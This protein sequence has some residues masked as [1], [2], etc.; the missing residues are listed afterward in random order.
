MMKIVWWG[1]FVGAAFW[2]VFA[3]VAYAV[4][5]TV[6]NGASSVGTVPGFPAEPFTF[7]WIA[8]LVHGFGVSAVTVTWLVGIAFIFAVPAVL[9][10]I[11]GRRRAQASL[12]ARQAGGSSIPGQSWGSSIPGGQPVSAPPRDRAA[13]R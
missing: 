11:F 10:R 13:G 8:A 5:D 3:W 2:S 1:A 4:V 12:P 6:G 9:Q 7:A